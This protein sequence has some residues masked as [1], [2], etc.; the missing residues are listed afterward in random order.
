MCHRY[1][2]SE[3]QYFFQNLPDTALLGIAFNYIL[4][5][6][7]YVE[8]GSEGQCLFQHLSGPALF[9][10]GKSPISDTCAYA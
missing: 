4:K 5:A 3:G 9:G 2:G 10:I 8:Q 1:P 6:C 7:R